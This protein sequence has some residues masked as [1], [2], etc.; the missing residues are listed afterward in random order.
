MK[1][2]LK[3]IQSIIIILTALATD[4]AKAEASQLKTPN[5]KVPSAEAVKQAQKKLKNGEAVKTKKL[6]DGEEP[7]KEK[8]EKNYIVYLNRI[9]NE[10][11]EI[12][13]NNVKHILETME[14]GN[15][16]TITKALEKLEADGKYVGKYKT[17]EKV[18]K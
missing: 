3:A 8:L 18:Q 7:K 13:L 17:F 9:P 16:D 12:T 2:I 14:S 10:Q 6:P 4:L 1:S 15:A 5:T 11:K